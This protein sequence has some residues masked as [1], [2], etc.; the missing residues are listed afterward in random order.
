VGPDFDGVIVGNGYFMSCGPH[1]LEKGSKYLI[2]GKLI[3]K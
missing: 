1:I 3:E 2:Y